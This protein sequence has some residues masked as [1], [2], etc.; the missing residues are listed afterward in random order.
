M[1]TYRGV[2]HPFQEQ[3]LMALSVEMQFTSNRHAMMI[4][5]ERKKKP[6]FE[7][8]EREREREGRKETMPI[9]VAAARRK[10]DRA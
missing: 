3:K 9:C 10:S 4:H 1:F 2:R 8:R 5:P 6:G 7:R